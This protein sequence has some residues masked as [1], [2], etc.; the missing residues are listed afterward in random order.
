ML[1]IWCFDENSLSTKVRT[2]YREN[3]YLTVQVHEIY[4][5]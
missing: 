2:G 3:I 5:C 4:D 1:M